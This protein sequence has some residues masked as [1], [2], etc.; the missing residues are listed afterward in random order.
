MTHGRAGNC[1]GM[2]LIEIVLAMAIVAVAG[3]F[4]VK[5][6]G[7]TVTTVEQV[8]RDRPLDRTRLAADQATLVTMRG[9]LQ[10]YQAQHGQWPSDRA[11]VL[12]ILG[13]PP[14]FQCAG[15]DFD[16]V[17]ATGALSLTVTDPGRC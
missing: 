3:F 16:Y 4:L 10:V 5:Y 11:A 14:R 8:Q 1:R 7:A 2:G 12:A 9:A 17:P 6:L 13:A 15:N